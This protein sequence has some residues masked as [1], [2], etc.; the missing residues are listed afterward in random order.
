MSDRAKVQAMRDV[1]WTPAGTYWR[2]RAEAAE[3]QCDMV[4]CQAFS[5]GYEA[6][7]R[8]ARGL[9]AQGNTAL[10]D[11]QLRDQIVGGGA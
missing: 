10:T 6:G 1:N 7:R 8:D 3:A 11:R 4:E 9:A 2:Q 5:A